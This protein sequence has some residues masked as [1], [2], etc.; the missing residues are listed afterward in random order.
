VRGTGGGTMQNVS[1][2]RIPLTEETTMQSA[3]VKRS[4][5]IAGHK[6][7]V[8]ME[9]AFW[10]AL[11]EIGKKQKTTISSLVADIDTRRRH[12]NLS[13]AI[14]LF[15]LDHVCS[16]ISAISID[17]IRANKERPRI[18]HDGRHSQQT[19]GQFDDHS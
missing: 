13:S 14:R 4:I 19:N 8:S 15:V 7:S 17:H 5:I 1:S 3:V 18:A 6:T 11:K 9:D 12:T 16:Q 10:N 2:M